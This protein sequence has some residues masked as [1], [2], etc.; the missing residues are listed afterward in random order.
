MEKA[1]FNEE[2][3]TM[4]IPI[5]VRFPSDELTVATPNTVIT[6]IPQ[7]MLTKSGPVCSELAHLTTAEHYTFS[8]QLWC[9]THDSELKIKSQRSSTVFRPGLMLVSG[10]DIGHSQEDKRNPAMD[11]ASEQKTTSC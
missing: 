11:A 6:S 8:S 5:K 2:V 4:A 10:Q 9:L 7:E 3:S 1:N